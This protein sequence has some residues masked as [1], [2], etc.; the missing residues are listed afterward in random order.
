MTDRLNGHLANAR[1]NPRHFG[2]AIEILLWIAWTFFALSWICSHR[3]P[4]LGNDSYQYLSEAHYLLYGHTPSTSLIY[5]DVERAHGQIPAPLTTFPPGYAIATAAFGSLGFGLES[6]GRL[7]SSIAISL[8]AGLLAA[9]LIGSGVG[10]V[11]RQLVMLFLIA[12]VTII[13]CGASVISDPLFTFLL[14]CLVAG[15]I[16][17]E[18]RIAAARSLVVPAVLVE[19]VAAVIC[20]VRYAGYFVIAAFFLYAFIQWMRFRSR[21]RAILMAAAFIP[22]LSAACLM[23]RNLSLTGNWKGG[24]ELAVHN[25]LAPLLSTYVL[26]HVHLLFGSHAIKFGVWET[27]LVLGV[28]I[29]AVA[30]VVALKGSVSKHDSPAGPHPLANIYLLTVLCVV[31]YT[32]AMLYAG[33]HTVISFGERMFMPLIPLYCLLLAWAI[34]ALDRRLRLAASR[35]RLW[36]TAG[37]ALTAIGYAGVNARDLSMPRKPAPHE[38]FATLYAMQMQ[39]GQT[40]SDWFRQT[41]PS[42]EPILSEEGQATG[43]L[44]DRPTVGM[45][46]SEYSA[47]RWECETIQPLLDRFHIHYVVL[48]RHLA[49]AQ[50][51]NPSAAVALLPESHFVAESLAGRPPCGFAVAAQNPDILV[52]RNPSHTY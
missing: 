25:R 50:S 12:N 52:L 13:L 4:N 36:L 47:T 5:F 33:L 15:F 29:L 22:L 44:L 39:N 6:A 48:Y 27:V 28:L 7:V 14:T 45:T 9:L 35:A 46:T 18:Y 21:Q 30:A 3:P 26:S 42:G 17:I 8:T 24:N 10:W 20:W 49:P 19:S 51:K 37:L 31:V 32:L 1:G 11:H 23:L 2:K 16:W 38:A 40:M 41:V 34:S 43:Y